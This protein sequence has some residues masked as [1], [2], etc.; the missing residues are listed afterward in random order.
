[1]ITI[2]KYNIKE[3][4]TILETLVTIYGLNRIK[5]ER[6]VIL[7]GFKKYTK[8]AEIPIHE[9]QLQLSSFLNVLNLDYFIKRKI[10]QNLKHLRVIR[11]Y[12][13]IRH[14]MGL[15]SRGG[16]THTNAKSSKLMKATNRDVPIKPVIK[17]ETSN[18][19]RFSTKH[20]KKGQKKFMKKNK[21]SKKYQ[22][23][24]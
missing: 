7:A 12:R 19:K 3:K 4:K 6:L 18:D 8:M 10:M 14:L 17:I 23:R 15:P 24:Y 11:S 21:N 22:K 1:M 9:I 5:A 16:R 20:K 2:G 13:G